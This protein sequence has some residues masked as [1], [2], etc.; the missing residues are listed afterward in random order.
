MQFSIFDLP[1]SVRLKERGMAIAA[2]HAESELERARRIAR[3]IALCRVDRLVTIDDVGRKLKELGL[4][5]SLGAASGSLFKEKC[6]K[7]TGRMTR[8]ARVSNHA[9]RVMIWEYIG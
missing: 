2:D 1:A 6:W 4:P 8:S 9:R 5:V 3:E 7:W